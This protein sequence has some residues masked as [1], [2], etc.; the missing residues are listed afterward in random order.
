MAMG[1]PTASHRATGRGS[2]T[3]GRPQL[4]RSHDHQATATA[5]STNGTNTL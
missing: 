2:R 4:E 3:P 5:T 1:S